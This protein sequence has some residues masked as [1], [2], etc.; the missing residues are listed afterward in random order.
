MSKLLAVNIIQD[1]ATEL[2][3]EE[4]FIEKDWY[5][6]EALK[7]VGGMK[8]TFNPVFSGGTSLSK[9]YNLIQRFSEDLDFKVIPLTSEESSR[10]ERKNFRDLLIERLNASPHFKV[11]TDTMESGNENKFFKFDI[12]Y[13]IQYA[14]EK[15][16]LRPHLRIEV[17]FHNS[18]SL[19]EQKKQVKSFIDQFSEKVEAF[20][21]DC[22]SPVETAADKASALIW[23]VHTR[24]RTQP[25]GSKNNDP[26]LIRHLHDLCALKETSL[27][28]LEFKKALEQAYENDQDRG[29]GKMKEI[30]LS[31]A[32]ASTY[33]II[34]EDPLYAKEYEE[35]VNGM[36]YARDEDLITYEKALSGLEG[37]VGLI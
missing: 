36:S 1:I 24:D 2:V 6:V 22:V 18:L 35:F 14:S 33:K 20:H 29:G 17:G 28:A 3:L 19:P 37:Y 11:I 7:I 21:I 9:G 23:R 5:A 13:P 16:T 15:R 32:L 8:G 34:Q 27:E 25:L 10:K 4:A 30:P 31:K 12:E 26:T